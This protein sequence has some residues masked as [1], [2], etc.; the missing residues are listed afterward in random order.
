M[1]TNGHEQYAGRFSLF[2]LYKR[3]FDEVVELICWHIRRELELFGQ[4][5]RAPKFHLLPPKIP[6]KLH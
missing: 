3:Y 1:V 2:I 6:P 4:T 5:V